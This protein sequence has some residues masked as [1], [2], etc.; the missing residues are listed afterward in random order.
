M[1]ATLL[2]PGPLKTREG[3]ADQTLHGG[4]Q[5]KPSAKTWPGLTGVR[6]NQKTMKDRRCYWAFLCSNH[7]SIWW[8]SMGIYG[9]LTKCEVKMAGYWPSSFFACLCTKTESRSINS[10]KKNEDNIQPS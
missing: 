2:S 5:L 4:E 8:M 1:T 9:L 7:T 10:Q 6:W 3:A